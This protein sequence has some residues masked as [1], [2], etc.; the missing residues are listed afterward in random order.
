MPV[1]LGATPTE[2]NFA[3]D[4]PSIPAGRVGVKWQ[5]GTAYP[6]PNIS[7]AQVRD[8]SG[9]VNDGGVNE[10]TGTSYTLV[11]GDNRKLVYFDNVSSPP[12]SIA[13]AIS[14]SADLGDHFF[15]W[16]ENLSEGTVTLTPDGSETI[17]GIADL[18]LEQGQGL[19]LFSDGSNLFTSRGR[20]GTG[21]FTAG[22]DLSGTSSSQTVVGL[23]GK[24]LDSS[25]VGSPS[26]GDVIAYDSAS[27]KYKASAPSGGGGTDGTP[28]YGANHPT[29]SDLSMGTNFNQ[30]GTF[31]MSD[32]GNG[33]LIQDT[34]GSAGENLEGVLKSYPGSAFTA[35]M[36]VS[37]PHVL[38]NYVQ[39]GMCAADSPTGK[40]MIFGARSATQWQA[41]KANF[42]TP[43][44]YASGFVA[45]GNFYHY[46][47]LRYKDDGTNIYF[48]SSSDGQY[49]KQH[50]T[51][52]KASSYLGSSGFNYWGI[53]LD[54]SNG[55]IGGV[56]MHYAET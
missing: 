45:Y 34:A 10:Q 47:W 40:M 29:I 43:S 35:T 30:A 15:C 25:T 1:S 48:Y 4:S 46:A 42:S 8:L 27:G 5:A 37:L 22:G 50:Y 51:V 7:G 53:Y 28:F 21:S 55:D 16:L 13:V 24:A 9:Y 38:Q 44:S 18:T 33:V 3:D 20:G 52:S 32:V 56:I 19:M 41:G 49:W 54:S 31:S 2:I 17:D 36:L 39:I 14:P 12:E 6:D 26:D 11:E 23:Q